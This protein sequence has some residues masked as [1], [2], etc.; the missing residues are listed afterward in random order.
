MLAIKKLLPQSLYLGGDGW[1]ENSWGF[2]EH[3]PNLNGLIGYT[4]RGNIPTDQALKS[5][6]LGRKVLKEPSKAKAIPS[7]G[8]ALTILKIFDSLESFLCTRKPKTRA[9]FREQ[10]T[11][12][13]NKFF[14]PSWGIGV[15]QLKDSK[16]TFHSAES[17]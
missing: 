4:A 10:F 14:I 3:G 5:F 2:V 13:R 7:S 6:S 8:S 9:A 15:Y 17:L 1:G 12:H 16:I 11:H